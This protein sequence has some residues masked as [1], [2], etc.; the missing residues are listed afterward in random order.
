MVGI[1]VSSLACDLECCCRWELGNC[2]KLE[3]KGAR[4]I[5]EDFSGMSF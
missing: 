5:L 3:R 1:Q 2:W 4:E